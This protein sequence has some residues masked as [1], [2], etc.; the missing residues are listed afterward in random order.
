MLLCTAAMLGGGALAI[1]EGCGGSDSP[2]SSSSSSSSS[3]STSGDNGSSSSSTSSSSSSGDIVDSGPP[4][5]TVPPS[6]PDQITCGTTV[7]DA[8]GASERVCCAR[9]GTQTGTACVKSNAC[10]NEGPDAS[11]QLQCDEMADCPQFGGAGQFGAQICCYQKQT[12]GGTGDN[13]TFSTFCETPHECRTFD[14]TTGTQTP[15]PILCH[16]NA[17]CADAGVD[18]GTGVAAVCNQKTC[19]GFPLFVCGNPAGCQ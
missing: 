16:T 11:I 19:D 5:V 3:S 10:D 12:F 8:G 13:H 2:A 1:I 6:N 14:I 7:C 15:A 17:E 4:P 18:A 9:P